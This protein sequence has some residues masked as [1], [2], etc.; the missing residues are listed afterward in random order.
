MFGRKLRIASGAG[1]VAKC[2]RTRGWDT[3][4]AGTPCRLG[5]RAGFGGRSG[6]CVRCSAWEEK[7]NRSGRLNARE[8]RAAS[9][10]LGY[11]RTLS[12]SERPLLREGTTEQYS[13]AYV[14]GGRS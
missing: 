11:Q 12:R 1:G 5:Y 10:A 8:G 6:A 3:V 2:A 13:G 7:P 14:A 4:P 9:T